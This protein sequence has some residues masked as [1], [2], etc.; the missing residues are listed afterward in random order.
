VVLLIAS[1]AGAARRTRKPGGAD[2]IYTVNRAS[3]EGPTVKGLEFLISQ[4]Q[5][6]RSTCDNG[7]RRLKDA[8]RE[9]TQA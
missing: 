1:P 3:G 2:A 4:R 6:V 8:A 5:G 9:S 7:A